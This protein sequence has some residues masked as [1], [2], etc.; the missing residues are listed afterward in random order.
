MKMS[1]LTAIAT[2][3]AFSLSSAASAQD[4]QKNTLPANR[5]GKPARILESVEV[6][7]GATTLYLSGQ[8]ASPINPATPPTSL[9]DMGNTEQQSRNIYEKIGKILKARGYEMR[10]VIKV[11]I[12]LAADPA[13]GKMDFAGANAAFDAYFNVPNNPTTV[14]RTT[15]EVSGFAGPYYLVEIE[16]VAAKVK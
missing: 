13:L 6:P 2:C 8:I 12:F 4:V 3:V 7:A 5:D 1:K 11:T 16:V 10:D 15:L 9:A 14:A